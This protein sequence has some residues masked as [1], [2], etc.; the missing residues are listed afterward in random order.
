MKILNISNKGHKTYLFCRDEQGNQV[1]Q[2]DSDF[3]PYYYEPDNNGTFRSFDGKK[4]RRVPCLHPFDIFKQKTDYSYEADIKY[5]KRYIID[6]IDT[7]DKCSIKWTMIDIEVESPEGFPNPQEAKFPI[8]CITAY[9]SF[10]DICHTW[11]AND[12][13]TE[14]EL[15]EAFAFWM[16][17]ERF[18]LWLSFNVGFDY[19]YIYNR[20]AKLFKQ[21]FAKYIS[22]IGQVRKERENVYPSGISICDYLLWYK[23]VFDNLPNY[24]LDSVFL[25]EFGHGKKYEVEDFGIVDENLRLHNIE[26][27]EGLV[28]IEKKHNLIEY[29]NEMRIFSRVEW[30]DFGMNSR[31]IDMLLLKEAKKMNVVLPNKPK[32]VPKIKGKKVKKEVEGAYREAF[33]L[34][35]F[36]NDLGKYDLDSA[37]PRSIL[38]YCLDISNIVEPNTPNAIPINVTDRVSQ[39]IKETYWVKQNQNT[40]LPTVAKNLISKK[41][42]LKN[43]LK[44]TNSESAEYPIL[45]KKYDALKG[46]VNSL[47]GTVILKVFRL[48]DKRVGG[49]ITSIPRDLLHYLEPRLENMGYV[50]IYIDTDSFF[51]LDGG[52]DISNILNK[53]IQ[54]WSQER[55]QKSTKIAFDYEGRYEKIFILALCHYRGWLKNKRGELKLENKG[56]EAKKSNSTIFLKTFQVTLLDKILD[57]EPKESIYEWVSSEM[58]RIKT[59]ELMDIA[60]PCKLARKVEDYVKKDEIFVRALRNAQRIIKYNKKIGERYYWIPITPE[61]GEDGRYVVGEKGKRIDVIAFDKK[62]NDHVDRDKIDWYEVIHKNIVKKA[63]NIFEVMGWDIKEILPEKPKRIRIPRTPKNK[64][65]KN[66]NQMKFEG[67]I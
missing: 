48:Y 62:K 4:L 37:Y 16:K 66:T 43:T 5:C 59:L 45:L 10:T 56:I 44:E 64:I 38:E 6:K 39:E 24:D 58:K 28:K 47:F 22:P 60:F 29:Y 65:E 53:L 3:R 40:L 19:P 13:D 11:F 57:K 23:K 21:D 34:G 18:D 15:V 36:Y 31:I 63:M 33:K 54:E 9:D 46:V 17:K 55:F 8:S 32:K 27:V 52:Q 2:E 7:F 50:I 25:K 14:E 51:I 42:E 12:Y 49:M 35:T 67:W 61:L 20:Y 41:T 26:D 1:I 30:E